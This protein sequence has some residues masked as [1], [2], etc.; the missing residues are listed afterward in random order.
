MRSRY[1]ILLLCLFL[2]PLAAQNF[3]V[4]KAEYGADATW[5]DVTGRLRDLVRGNGIEFTVDGQTLGDPL[6]GIQK[7]LR[8]RY[9]F[10]NR[11]R[12]ENFKDLEFVRLGNPSPGGAING[13]FPAQAAALSIESARYGIGNRWNDVT[14]FLN[15]SIQNNTLRVQVNNASMGGD[16]APANEKVLEV[17][18]RY[19]GQ[20]FSATVRENQ[21]LELPGGGSSGTSA[22]L[23]ILSARYGEGFRANDVTQFLN[24]TIQNN[25]L[26]VQVNTGS[27]G[28]DPAPGLAKNLQVQYE[29]NGVR[30]TVTV[31]DGEMLELPG[32]T[33][34]KDI[35]SSDNLQIESATYGTFGRNVDVTEVI[36]R[37]IQ[38]NRVR[39]TVNDAT[40]G[41][42]PSSSRNDELVVRYILNGQ[43]F[44]KTVRERGSLDLP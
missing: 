14:R 24:N 20:S 12:T 26:R 32:N 30:N 18:Y 29:Y 15:N 37:A 11:T 19:Q 36:R 8:V 7:T 25:T 34:S 2:T 39:L 22:S 38:S 4:I 23:R 10:R 42:N 28:G 13:N 40:M 3:E 27:M 33:A 16:P 1:S 35:P 43:R 44:T 6:P 9:R 21:M 41:A 5:T 17:R 31:R